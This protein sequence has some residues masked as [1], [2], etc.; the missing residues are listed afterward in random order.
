ML[1]RWIF[2][3]RS[4]IQINLFEFSLQNTKSNQFT[5]FFLSKHRFI[6]ISLILP[7]KTQIQINLLDFSCQN[8]NLVWKNI[9]SNVLMLTR[10]ISLVK[11]QIQ[12]NLFEFSCRDKNLCQ[13]VGFF[14]SKH[15][16]AKDNFIKSKETTPTTSTR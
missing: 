11:T 4:W 14:L 16:M 5:R 10:L 8:T 7:V 2:L 6:W 12:I 13:F 1:T 15:S 3:A 9:K